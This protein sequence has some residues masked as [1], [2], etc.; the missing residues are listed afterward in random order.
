[1]QRNNNEHKLYSLIK[2]KQIH[3]TSSKGNIF[4]T[5]I[6]QTKLKSFHNHN[7]KQS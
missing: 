3:F 6:D 4:N 2:V 5:F 7:E 1:M